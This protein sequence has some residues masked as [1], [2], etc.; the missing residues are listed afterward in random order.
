[1][2][3]LH[4][5]RG[6]ER[7]E[8]AFSDRVN[9][10]WNVL[11][12]P[13]RRAEYD[14]WLMGASSAKALRVRVAAARTPVAHAP[15][16]SPQAVRRL[17]IFV[18]AG[19]L[20]AGV[21]AALWMSDSDTR[22]RGT[23]SVP[24]M[25]GEK[26]HQ[27]DIESQAAQRA[28]GEDDDSVDA[29]PDAV[30]SAAAVDASAP[31]SSSA[32]AEDASASATV[33]S[34]MTDNA[35]STAETESGDATASVADQPYV[36][37]SAASSIAGAKANRPSVMS[38]LAQTP[39]VSAPSRMV[40]TRLP[41]PAA[42]REAAALPAHA[43]PVAAA[44][45]PVRAR[46][47]LDS[48]M[49]NPLPVRPAPTNS[50]APVAGPGQVIQGSMPVTP[51]AVAASPRRATV[52]E[53]SV[54]DRRES[55]APANVE[56]PERAST[57]VAR[58]LQRTFSAAYARG[59]L[60]G[61]MRLFADD[62]TENRDDHKAI[63]DD[64]RRLFNQ[65]SARQLDLDGLTWTLATDRLVGQGPFVVRMRSLDRG[66]E[67]RVQGWIRIEARLRDGEWKI[68]RLMHGSDR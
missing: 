3:W 20:C 34:A 4:P 45:Q 62:A 33:A 36:A 17:P 57:Q 7:W 19:L 25:G 47:A 46:P 63:V 11:R 16:L 53:S 41:V 31:S 55:D 28:L 40:A 42:K 66:E 65:T 14:A 18:L 9:A 5:D 64:Y 50:G 6:G 59:D 24:R 29:W 22:S 2:R 37:P 49:V 26:S 43:E 27:S 13:E 8:T 12:S 35:Q 60:A 58:D 39:A 30:R 21:A 61:M 68:Q 54:Q 51:R 1:M 23:P 10:A 32:E 48:P 56:I 38:E 52:V 67:R 15:I 44:T